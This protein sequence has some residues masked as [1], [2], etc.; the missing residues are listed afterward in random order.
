EPRT[1]ES[2]SERRLFFRREGHA[3]PYLLQNRIVFF[4]RANPL[5]PLGNVLPLVNAFAVRANLDVADGLQ[6]LILKAELDQ[7]PRRL[8]RSLTATADVPAA[9]TRKDIRIAIVKVLMIPK[10]VINHEPFFLNVGCGAGS[11]SPH[12]LV[13]DWAPDS[14]AHQQMQ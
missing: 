12:L 9:R 14:P 8:T 7:L 3:V 6:P 13:E 11:S 4:R 1:V 5:L 10:E 2:L